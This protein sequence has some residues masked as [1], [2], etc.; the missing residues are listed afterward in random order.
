[1]IMMQICK[2]NLFEKKREQSLEIDDIKEHQCKMENILFR[3][4]ILDKTYKKKPK[5]INKFYP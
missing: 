2:D 5:N 4:L 1:M 3:Y